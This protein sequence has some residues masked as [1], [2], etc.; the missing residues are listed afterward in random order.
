M[1]MSPITITSDFN[2]IKG[3]VYNLIIS[4]KKY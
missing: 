3:N 4:L 1:I 2:V